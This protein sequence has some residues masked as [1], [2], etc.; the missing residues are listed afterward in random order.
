MLT[1][2]RESIS[3]I[4][5]QEKEKALPE[6]SLLHL[7]HMFNWK[8]PLS[9]VIE[10]GPLV[11]FCVGNYTHGFFFGAGL[12]VASVPLSLILGFI[13]DRRF[14]VFPFAVGM[15]ILLLGGATVVT[16]NATWLKL[17]FTL[18][19]SIFGLSL[20]IGVALNK[21]LLKRLFDDI[22]EI[23]DAG[24]LTLSLRWGIYLVFV[25]IANEVLRR[26]YPTD[27]WADY[28]IV[29]AIVGVLFALSQIGLARAS[30][31]PTA[32]VWGFK[33]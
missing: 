16:Q 6:E 29:F 1:S 17:E 14:A 11:A 25:G 33:K 12:L 31:L 3:D 22:L 30:R 24:W 21:P 8:I 23:T 7:S 26:F 4:C 32:S 15:F 2:A 9:F 18:Y 20:L 27:V 19:N 10:F 28:R 13:R 5:T